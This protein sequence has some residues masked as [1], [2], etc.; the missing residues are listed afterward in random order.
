MLFLTATL[1]II[2][3]ALFLRVM[4]L[5]AEIARFEKGAR[6]RT[7]ILPHDESTLNA[8]GGV[9]KLRREI[10]TLISDAEKNNGAR[11]DYIRQIDTSL[12]SIREAVIIVDDENSVLMANEAAKNIFGGGKSLQ[13]R[14]IEGFMTSVA[15]LDYVRDLRAGKASG[16]QI[17]EIPKDDGL[18]WFEVTGSIIKSEGTSRDLCIFVLH[19]ITKLKALENM[20]KEFVAN[21]SH[22][23]RTPVTVIRGFTDMMIEEGENLSPEERSRFLDKIQRNVARLGSLLEDLL[24]LS[25]LEGD[26]KVLQ[27][28]MQDLNN[29]VRETLENFMDR[30]PEGCTIEVDLDTSIPSLKLD[31]M[32]ISQILDNL[33][34]N[35]VRHARG[36]K[37]IKVTTKA[38]DGKVICS[39]AD[40]GCGIPAA[41]VPHIFERFYRVDKGRSRELGGTGLGLAIV[42]HAVMQHGGNVFIESKVGQGT[43]IG[44]TLPIQ[45]KEISKS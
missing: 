24:T 41:D 16:S 36:M 42:K 44:F 2:A 19:D 40:D 28:E 30:K 21:V 11:N 22:E 8:G 37:K 4:K 20:R 25:R 34:D 18:L 15:F 29:I 33:L 26:T 35:A 45:T 43:T 13:G 1:A 27:I 3:L 38:E 17:V 9:E 12:G 14:R 31:N 7:Q 5:R 6:E 32:R 39:V 10:N 23:L